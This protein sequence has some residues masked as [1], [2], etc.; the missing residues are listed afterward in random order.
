LESATAF[1]T[2]S[3]AS[4]KDRWIFVGGQLDGVNFQLALDF[5]DGTPGM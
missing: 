1:F 2:A 4:A 5:F 3:T